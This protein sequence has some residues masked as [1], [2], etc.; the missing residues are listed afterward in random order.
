M[1]DML[2]N[3]EWQMVEADCIQKRRIL[4]SQDCNSLIDWISD[5]PRIH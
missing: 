1:C 3:C 4:Q 2:D 5:V